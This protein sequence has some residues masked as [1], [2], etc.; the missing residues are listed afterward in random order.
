MTDYLHGPESI[1]L[2]NTKTPIKVLSAS[3]IGLIATSDNADAAVFPLDE[4]TLVNSEKQIAK[5]GDTGTLKAA[6]QDIYAHGAAVVVVIRVKEET[7]TATQKAAIVGKIDNE[8][9]VYTG[10]KAFQYAES[11]LGLKPRLFIAPELS[12]LE[13][14]GVELESTAAKLKGIAIID[15]TETG[16]SKVIN[17]RKKYSKNVLFVNCGI[18]RLGDDGNPVTRKASAFVAGHIVRVDN[19]EGYWHSPSNRKF[20]GS[21]LGTSEPIDHAIGSRTSKANLYNEQNVCVIVKQEGGWFFY[22]NRLADGTLL[23]HQRIRYIVGESIVK[24]HQPWVDRN[25]T[26]HYIDSVKNR[27]NQLIRRLV[28]RGV[29]SGGNCW[30][31][32]ELNVTAIGSNQFYW[33]Y[34]LGFYDVAE[35]MTFTQSVNSEKY[36]QAFLG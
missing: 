18:E 10:L 4:P 5:A 30:I 14:I 20:A 8:K 2:E 7:D 27:V 23:T 32:E 12:H 28:A 16:F 31:D 19:D 3:V 25:I 6:L 35:R 1:Y 36:N 9:H 15:G 24:A 11:K 21:L 34:E 33:N 29:I 17:E 22:G 26:A 13:G